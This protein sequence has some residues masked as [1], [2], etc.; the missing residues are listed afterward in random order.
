MD[1][2]INLYL[3]FVC[4]FSSCLVEEVL[5]IVLVR[6]IELIFDDVL[7]Y[8]DWIWEFDFFFVVDFKKVGVCI[9]FSVNYKDLMKFFFVVV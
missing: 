6:L 3:F 4:L 9:K 5:F 1:G 2:I 8:Y 7:Y